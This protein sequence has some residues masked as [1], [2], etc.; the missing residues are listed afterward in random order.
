MKPLNPCFQPQPIKAAEQACAKQRTK[1][2][3]LAWV[4]FTVTFVKRARNTQKSPA[5][6]AGKMQQDDK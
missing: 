6:K 5:L 3:A 1:P 4:L 2:G